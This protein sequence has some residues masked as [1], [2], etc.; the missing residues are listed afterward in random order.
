MRTF[1]LQVL[2]GIKAFL[3]LAVFWAIV[4]TLIY[5]G[6]KDS[7]PERHESL[8]SLIVLYFSMALAGGAV[9]GALR[10][11]ATTN[12]RF[13]VMSIAVAIPLAAC[14]LFMVKGWTLAA[15]GSGDLVVFGALAIV[16]G[17]TFGFYF[18]TRF[19]NEQG[20]AGSD[21]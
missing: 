4:A 1:S 10:R 6:S 13:A 15:I 12:L 20:S 2:G 7:H 18:R 5:S 19:S 16:F 8:P 17:P 14:V 11:W 21:A 9:F 3:P